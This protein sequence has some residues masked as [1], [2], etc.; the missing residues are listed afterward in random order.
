MELSDNNIFFFI[1][2]DLNKLD[3]IYENVCDFRNICMCE[4]VPERCKWEIYEAV[5]FTHFRGISKLFPFK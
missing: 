2:I 3:F 5:D 4:T 1:N